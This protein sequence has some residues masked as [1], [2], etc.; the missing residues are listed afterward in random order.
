MAQNATGPWNERA[1]GYNFDATTA[2][3]MTL[4]KSFRDAH[5]GARFEDDFKNI[6]AD[7]DQELRPQATAPPGFTGDDLLIGSLLIYPDE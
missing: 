7:I 6:L 2:D 5:N 3:G 1:A 4:E